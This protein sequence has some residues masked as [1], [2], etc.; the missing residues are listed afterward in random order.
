MLNDELNPEISFLIPVFNHR[1]ETQ[2]MFDSLMR[3]IPK[4]ASFEI[5]FI[6]DHSND[7]T[8]NWLRSIENNQVKIIRNLE[9]K[10]Y[11]CSNNQAAKIAKGRYLVLLNN[12]LVMTAGWLEPMLDIINT[13]NDVGVV[14]NVQYRVSDQFLDHLGFE[15][16]LQGQFQH[17]RDISKIHHPCLEVLAVTGAC[18]LIRK[19]DFE[20]VGGFD[21]RFLNGCEDIDLC[22]KIKNLG[23][24][25]VVSTQSCIQH[26]V[27]LTRNS[28]SLQ[29]ELNSRYLF[30][31]WRNFIKNYLCHLWSALLRENDGYREYIDGDLKFEITGDHSELSQ[32]ICE[33]MIG[34]Q[35][36]YWKKI[37]DNQDSIIENDC[38]V[39][40]HGIL[41][42]QTMEA[43]LIM[44]TVKVIVEPKDTIENF[45]FCGKKINAAISPGMIF[46]I[47]INNLQIKNFSIEKNQS[48]FNIGIA[49]P[50]LIK[51]QKNIIE[52][53]VFN[54][55][56]DNNI[57]DSVQKALILDHVVMNNQVISKFLN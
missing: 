43:Y 35:E 13:Q 15:I 2:V 42:L 4:G 8:H 24:S 1:V 22:F 26:H 53:K 16:N 38:V 28:K 14:G 41:P 21:E 18:L 27:S 37:I 45:Y 30:S 48:N 6:D 31:R 56:A 47:N 57:G 9:N 46:Q 52:L 5:I 11:A 25:I 33:N 7:E 17:I 19:S 51:N 12:D 32:L 20:L 34:R 50:L 36:L 44:E 55:S 40:I 29:Q 23:L 10:G 3:T 54:I 39:N 49:Y